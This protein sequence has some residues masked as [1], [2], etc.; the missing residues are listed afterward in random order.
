MTTRKITFRK[1]MQEQQA[2]WRAKALPE[3]EERGKWRGEPYD[4]ILP[5]SEWTMGL[6]PEIQAAIPEYIAKCKIKPHTAKNSLVSSW[7]LGANLYFP[8]G[9]L[10]EGKQVLADFLRE[11]VDSRIQAVTE[12]ILEFEE[13]EPRG[14][15]SILGEA[16]GSRGANQTSPDVAVRVQLDDGTKGLVLVE[17]SFCEATFESCSAKEKALDLLDARMKCSDLALVLADPSFCCEQHAS[18][19]RRYF[20]HLGKPL[21]NASPAKGASCPA[22]A[23]GYQLFRQQALAEGL[24][25]S[26]VYGLVASC[27]AYHEGNSALDGCL[28]GSGI[29]HV[30]EW[31]TLF[32]GRAPF[33]AFSHQDWARYVASSPSAERWAFWIEWVDTRYELR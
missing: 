4:H 33:K 24:A 5:Q 20:D 9:Q 8:F 22:A 21:A 11:A 26:G 28:K 18:V 31:G 3:I 14:T 23:N 13:E 25:A 19:G 1:E 17:V 12:V 16:G 32:A 15:Q 27:L 6:Y 2:K 29:S 10:L 7:V 30:S